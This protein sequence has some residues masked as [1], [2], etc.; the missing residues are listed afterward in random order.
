LWIKCEI[1]GL[2]NAEL[3]VKDLYYH[4]TCLLESRKK[5][6]SSSK[7]EE[8]EYVV[9]H[10]DEERLNEEG[11]QRKLKIVLIL[12]IISGVIIGVLVSLIVNRPLDMFWLIPAFIALS[13]LLILVGYLFLK[14]I[15]Y[16]SEILAK[17]ED[18]ITL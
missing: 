16:Y 12:A 3:R 13:L 8:G 4:K 2:E 18:K 10:L 15:K 1:C 14:F 11:W 17:I 6:A 5:V 7:R 9:G